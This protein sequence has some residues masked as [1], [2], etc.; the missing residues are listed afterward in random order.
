MNKKLKEYSWIAENN[1][2]GG[3]IILFRTGLTYLQV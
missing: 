1:Q 2:K 3:T